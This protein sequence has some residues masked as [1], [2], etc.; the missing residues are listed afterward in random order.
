MKKANA[1]FSRRF[2]EMERIASESG[3][4]FANTP[5]PQM[6]AFWEQAKS[7]LSTSTNK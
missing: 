4:T 3:S 5:R 1:K 2:R 7:R 6:E